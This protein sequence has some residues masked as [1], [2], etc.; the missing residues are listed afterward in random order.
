MSPELV[1]LG[2]FT[3]GSFTFG[4]LVLYWYGFLITLGALAAAYLASLE[5]RRRNIDPDHVWNALIPVL[6]LGLLGARLYHVIS[7][8]PGGIGWDYYR[9]HPI[10]IIAFWNGGLRGL[11]IYGAIIG[12]LVGLWLYCR[13]FTRP[14]LSTLVFM[15]M[16]APGLALAQ[17]VGR[18]GN[19]FNQELYG[20]PTTLPWGVA[21][22]MQH[23][24]PVFA[25]LPPE[26]RFHPTFAYESIL[27]L[28]TAITL[29][30]VGRRFSQRLR[31]G[32]IFLM[33]LIMY[34]LAR[35]I[36]EFQRPDAWTIAGLPTAQWIAVLTAVG[37]A[38]A[39]IVRHRLQLPDRF[40]RSQVTEQPTDTSG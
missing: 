14:P 38:I 27:N 39:L 16:V 8:P 34:P 36:V 40:N 4:P 28:L 9:E 11:G 15:D 7:S 26:T 17:A 13:F 23:R 22:D 19:F 25:D 24:L 2:P 35:F 5:A 31:P 32:D 3:I 37:A 10:D 30:Y 1:R 20:Y 21:I 33:Y 18:W 12:G 29:I 6:L